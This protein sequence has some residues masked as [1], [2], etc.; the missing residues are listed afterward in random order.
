MKN[1][2]VKFFFLLKLILLLCLCFISCCCFSQKKPI[3][4]V[5]NVLHNHLKEDS[6]R[7]SALNTLS[8]LYQ[9]S[10]LRT[11]EYYALEA[12]SIAEKINDD[13]SK[14]E[15]LSH[16]SSVYAWQRKTTEALNASFRQLEIAKKINS[17]YWMQKAYLGVAYVYELENEWGKAL[18]YSLMAMPYAEKTGDPYTIGFLYD[19]IGSEYLGV[20]NTKSAEEYLRK[21]CSILKKNGN[22]DEL[23]DSEINLAKV[24]AANGELDSSVL[25][26]N[27]AVSIFTSQEEPYQIADA[28]QQ[29]GDMYEQRGMHK[30]A[31][32]CYKQTILN[33]NKNDVAEADYALA[34]LG[35]GA[36]DWAEKHYEAASK[37]FHEE[38][39]KIKNA[40]IIEP[41][42]KYL[43]YMAKADSLMGNYKE[44]FE[45]ML[46]YTSLYDSFYNQEKTKATQRML[47]DFDVQRKEKENEKLKLQNSL[48]KEQMAIFAVTGAILLIAGVFLALMYRQKNAALISVKHLQLSTESKNSELA[49][50]NAVKDKLIS[51]I[52]HDVRSP[53]TSLQNTLYLTREKIINEHEFDRLSL[54]LDNDI[55]HLIT[56]L[57][58][59]L[60]WAREQ[61]HALKISKEPFDLHAMME[62]VIAL[63]YQPIRDKDLVVDN[64]IPPSSEIVSDKEIIHTV[65]RNLISNAIKFTPPGKSIVLQT[66]LASGEILV[67]VKDEGSGIADEILNKINKKE[68]ISTRGTNNE[69]GTGLGLMFSLELLSKLGEKISI[70]TAE[71]KGTAVTFSVST[72]N[73][74]VF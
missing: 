56:M 70:K 2:L 61:I 18:K 7:V 9:T 21:A 48:Q 41:Q 16:V 10:N 74:S 60:L 69:K 44:A 45:H 50:I 63:Y 54:M 26:F 11:A 8:A 34:I 25:Y 72:K 57:D 32:A 35:L 43:K 5:L 52:A 59:T 64:R 49:I 22:K 3:D 68:F 42:L 29:M 65:L 17:D 20:G 19:Y 53:L 51:M 36:V 40:G 30:E 15:A 71:G 31:K 39:I 62:D 28:Y 46:V 33:Y 66:E 4:S 6:I 23:G 37:I 55:R 67:S 24:F 14:C 73:L 12:L 27:Y 1:L 47:I 58:N 38:F 13:R